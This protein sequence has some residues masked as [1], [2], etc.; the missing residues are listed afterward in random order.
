M[1][2]RKIILITAMVITALAILIGPIF[3]AFQKPVSDERRI[4]SAI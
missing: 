3:I 1:N 4:W 2:V